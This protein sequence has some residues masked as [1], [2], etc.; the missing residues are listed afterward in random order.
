MKILEDSGAEAKSLLY[1][2]DISW[3]CLDCQGGTFDDLFDSAAEIVDEFTGII[4]SP[5]LFAGISDTVGGLL[6]SFLTDTFPALGEFLQTEIG[7]FL[8]T[9]FPALA[10]PQAPQSQGNDVHFPLHLHTGFFFLSAA[11]LFAA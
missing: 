11:W 6:T 7:E 5:E 1:V 8:E 10:A 4:L 3:L 9:V 2:I